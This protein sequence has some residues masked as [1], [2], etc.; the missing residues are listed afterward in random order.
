VEPSLFGVRRGTLG[1]L[2]WLV[3]MVAVG[4]LAGSL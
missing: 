2:C 4:F 3:P 1:L